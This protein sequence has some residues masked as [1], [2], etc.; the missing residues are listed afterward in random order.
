MQLHL[1]KKKFFSKI[2]L[3]KY[4]MLSKKKKKNFKNLNKKI[5]C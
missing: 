5:F 4:L 2:N 1:S 3:N